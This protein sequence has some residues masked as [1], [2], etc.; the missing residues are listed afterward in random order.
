MRRHLFKLIRTASTDGSFRF[1]RPDPAGPCREKNLKG[2]SKSRNGKRLT[3]LTATGTI[4]PQARKRASE[5]PYHPNTKTIKT[6]RIVIR[7]LISTSTFPLKPKDGLPRFVLDLAEALAEKCD[8]IVLAPDAVDCLKREAVGRI[9]VRRFTYFY[10]RRRQMLA[11]GYGIRE[12]LRSSF[13][14]KIQLLPFVAGQ[15]RATRHLVRSNHTR[16]VNSH[17]MIPQGLSSALV[18]GRQKRF[19]H[20]LSVHAG[21]VYMMKRMPFG[22]SLARFIM[23][24]TDFVFVDGSKVLN[25]LDRLLGR[26]SMGVVQPMGVHVDRF[27][28]PSASPFPSPFP[29][30]YLLFFRKIRGK[31]RHSL[32]ARIDA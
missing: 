28:N 29:D 1:P 7:T 25:E 21:D 3:P 5:L 22:R 16:V 4:P 27:R 15:V 12:N 10:P 14:A 30:G 32:P 24:R 20:I 11:Y 18:R 23:E 17:W 31:K 2:A 6:Y 8:V 9:D 19:H 26:P 13:S